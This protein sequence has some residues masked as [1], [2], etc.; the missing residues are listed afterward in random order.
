VRGRGERLWRVW[1]LHR[2]PIPQFKDAFAL[3]SR[4][5]CAGTSLKASAGALCSGRACQWWWCR[6]APTGARGAAWRTASWATSQWARSS[7]AGWPSACCATSALRAGTPS[8][9]SCCSRQRC[10]APPSSCASRSVCAA[11]G[12]GARCSFQRPCV[13]SVY[14]RGRMRCWC[15]AEV[16][17]GFWSAAPAH[18]RVLLAC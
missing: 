13:P 16:V 5:G 17:K 3:K 10:G 4:P 6:P 14:A 2:N 15:S 18:G 11:A 12:R 9:P 8:A 7:L 1:T